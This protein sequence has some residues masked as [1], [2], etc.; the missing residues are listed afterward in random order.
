MNSVAMSIIQEAEE[1]QAKGKIV[2]RASELL[3]M[4]SEK[5]PTL[6]DP[7]F[8]RCA[9]IAVAGASDAGKSIFQRQFGIA[10]ASGRDF[11]GWKNNARHKSAIIVST[12]D[13]KEAVSYLIRKQN[14]TLDLL[15]EQLSGLRYIFDPMDIIQH[16]DEELTKEP[17][18]A[19]IIDAYADV[20][21]GKDSKDATQVRTFLKQYKELS[22]KHNC[23]VSFLH[24]TGKRTEDYA[25][26]KNNFIG[27]QS[28]E[29]VMRLCIELRID[30][31]NPQLRHLCIV[32]GNYLP[33]EYKNRSF[34]LSLDENL[35]FS[36]TRSRI[37]F[38]ELVKDPKFGKSRTGKKPKDISQEKHIEFLKAQKYPASKRGLNT[39]IREFF[40]IGESSARDYIEFYINEGY[41]TTEKIGV[42]EKLIYKEDE[43]PF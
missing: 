17:A 5:I 31:D 27:S 20:F 39:P 38:D 43:L 12:E 13:D 33:S 28:F 19:V 8:P 2:Y 29:A 26:S 42:F 6:F 40:D 24:H 11:L 7:I 25:P 9:V 14:K 21:T 3:Q 41:L 36:D 15:P 16:L 37:S 32:K 18:D 1:L 23:L 10:I 4:N 22:S 30:A 35:V 34:V